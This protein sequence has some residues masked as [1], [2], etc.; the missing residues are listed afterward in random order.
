M[1]HNPFAVVSRRGRI[2]LPVNGK[3]RNAMQGKGLVGLVAGLVLVSATA[4]YATQNWRECGGWCWGSRTDATGVQADPASQQLRAEL[5][6]KQEEVRKEMS[7][8]APDLDRVG[9]LQKEAID[10]RVKLAKAGG[11]QGAAEPG[12][13]C[14][15]NGGGGCR[16]DPGRGCRNRGW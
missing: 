8:A 16:P 2:L 7:A 15:P 6:A 11:L 3:R 5:A 12:R 13:G 1:F 14:G 10:I 4:V 9:S